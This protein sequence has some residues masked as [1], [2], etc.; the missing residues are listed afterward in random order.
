LVISDC[1]AI[2]NDKKVVGVFCAVL[3]TTGTDHRKADLKGA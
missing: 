3:V 1:L 2:Y